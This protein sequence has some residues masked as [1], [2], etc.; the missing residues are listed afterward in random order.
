MMKIHQLEV[1]KKVEL[2]GMALQEMN[3][4]VGQLISFNGEEDAWIVK[5]DGEEQSTAIKAQNLWCLTSDSESMA[6]QNAEPKQLPNAG[7]ANSDVAYIHSMNGGSNEPGSYTG[8]NRHI[9]DYKCY[10]Y[11]KEGTHG[12]MCLVKKS[13]ESNTQEGLPTGHG[14]L[15]RGLI[16]NPSKLGYIDQVML[17]DDYKRKFVAMSRINKESILILCGA[18]SLTK[19]ENCKKLSISAW[20]V[21]GA[22]NS[23]TTSAPSQLALL[24]DWTDIVPQNPEIYPRAAYYDEYGVRYFLRKVKQGAHIAVT[25]ISDSNTDPIIETN[26]I[27]GLG[28]YLC[29]GPVRIEPRSAATQLG[30]SEVRFS[31][32]RDDIKV[33]ELRKRLLTPVTA[34]HPHLVLP[35]F[36]HFACLAFPFLHG[37]FCM[38]YSSSGS[39]I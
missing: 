6:S 14:L 23:P 39:L 29:Y 3:G 22:Q 17:F 24:H 28:T 37:I 11:L 7:Y 31:D 38:M 30:R 13:D 1:G 21:T 15:L 20:I 35:V 27:A 12:A 18:E 33:S 10:Y 32:W 26:W 2:H 25:D 5:F 4:R 8:P 16:S 19:L 34:I 9:Q 36:P